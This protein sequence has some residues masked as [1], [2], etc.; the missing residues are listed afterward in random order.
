MATLPA[1]PFNT[2][3]KT[4]GPWTTPRP[5][6]WSSDVSL[7]C[8]NVAALSNDT[9]TD[10]AAWV[11]HASRKGIEAH[12]RRSGYCGSSRTRRASSA[13]LAK[14]W[15]LSELRSVLLNASAAGIFPSNLMA[16][17]FGK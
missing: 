8:L 13:G 12:C 17:A 15:T 4:E 7:K 2:L 16:A 1:F 5:K 3:C 14:H 9:L 6:F 11:F 10:S